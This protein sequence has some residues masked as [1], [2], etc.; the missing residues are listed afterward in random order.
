[1]D[2]SRWIGRLRGRH[3]RR[4]AYVREL[5]MIHYFL[6][7]DSRSRLMAKRAWTMEDYRRRAIYLKDAAYVVEVEK[8]VYNKS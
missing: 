7:Y 5:V 8:E 3:Y 1:M 2:R 6:F 4:I